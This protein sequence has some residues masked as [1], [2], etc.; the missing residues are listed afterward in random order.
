MKLSQ[1]G[2]WAFI[3]GLV[4]AVVA[5]VCLI[6]CGVIALITGKIGSSIAQNVQL[7]PADVSASAEKVA[8]FEL[9][10]GFEPKTSMSILGMTFLMYE[11]PEKDSAMVIVQMPSSM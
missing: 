2:F 7:E 4:L 3:I 11:A 6:G 8:D 1:I 10:A 5:V 9:P